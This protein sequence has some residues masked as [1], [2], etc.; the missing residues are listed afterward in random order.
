MC[1]IR[2]TEFE[3]E[4]P[5]RALPPKEITPIR[6]RRLAGALAAVVAAVA[7]AAVLMFPASTPAVS[8]A[9]TPSAPEMSVA[10][11]T[12][13]LVPAVEQSSSGLDD[14]VPM[15]AARGHCNHEL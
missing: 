9:P 15:V 3:R 14:G 11:S 12:A 8:T 5:Q 13:P 7:A 10:Q 2:D 6:Q 1:L 4:R